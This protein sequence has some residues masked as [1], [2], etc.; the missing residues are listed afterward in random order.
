ME[1]FVLA[2]YLLALK[3][4]M[5]DL[6]A[7]EELLNLLVPAIANP[8]HLK[9]R[10]G[11]PYSYDSGSAAPIFTRKRN[12]TKKIKDH[13]MDDAVVDTVGGYFKKSVCPKLIPSR[14]SQ[15]TSRLKLMVES[16]DIGDD[17]KGYLLSFLTADDFPGFLGHTFL[18]VVSYDN[19]GRKDSDSASEGSGAPARFPTLE[20]IDVPSEIADYEEPYLSALLAA[21]SEKEGIEF[22]SEG[23]LEGHRTYQKHFQ[24]A[25]SDFFSVESVRRGTRDIYTDEDPDQFEV[26]KDEIFEGV[27]E[28]HEDEHENGF[29]RAHAVLSLAANT[30]ITR[31]WLSRDTDWIGG[32]Q[33]KGVCHFLI[34]ESRLNGWVDSDD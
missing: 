27:I 18:E 16:S 26:L 19:V 9:N 10:N 32:K 30:P 4:A 20:N 24:R 34:N 2:N 33:R 1:E 3:E 29:A 12:L 13:C 7:N 22:L 15:L 17:R 23:M 28:T 21:Y 5:K 25:R 14:I 31:S 11:E 8:A 6:N